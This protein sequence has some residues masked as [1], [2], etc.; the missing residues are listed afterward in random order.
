MKFRTFKYFNARICSNNSPPLAYSIIMP[1][2][3]S[4][5]ITSFNVTIN[6]C[7]RDCRID[8]SL[9]SLVRFALLFTL[10]WVVN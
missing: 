1:I 8:I 5:S 10:A 7:F 6:G 3:E 4:V 2:Y 9:I